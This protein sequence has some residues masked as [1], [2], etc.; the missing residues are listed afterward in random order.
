MS[1]GARTPS[2]ILFVMP[3]WVGDA[4]LA[5]PLIEAIH[6][7]HPQARKDF[8][9]KPYLRGLLDDAPWLGKV[10]E[11]P[12][13]RGLAGFRSL[14]GELARDGYD[15][16]IL[17]PNSFRPALLAWASGARRRVGYAR[18]GRS[19]LLT[20]RLAFPDRKRRPFRMVDFYGAIGTALGVDGWDRPLRLYVG[21]EVAARA[22]RLFDTYGLT[23]VAP[24]IG[25]NP[26]AKY[27]SSKL[28]P[29]QHFAE[30]ADA[31][32]ERAG[33]RIVVLAGPGEDELANDI[34]Q[35]M[36]GEAVVLPSSEVDLCLLK[37]VLRKLD[38]LISNDTGPRHMAAAVGVPTVSIFGPTHTVW[39][40]T[41]YERSVN[42]AIKVDCGPCMQRTCPQGHHKCMVELKPSAVINAARALLERYPPTPRQQA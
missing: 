13:K 39:G 41:G 5:T 8:L 38:L 18:N 3:T 36:D 2:R 22:D 42:L 30:T 7:R 25:V 27:G 9:L 32:L 24:L 12:R 23:G 35:R 15:W 34:R 28:W 4:A 19:P 17:L 37:G 6:E 29:A 20:D 26:G 33:G 11:W 21:E 1:D 14:R 10:H 40:D 16:A 31:M